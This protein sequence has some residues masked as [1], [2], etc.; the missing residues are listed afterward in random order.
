MSSELENRLARCREILRSLER[1]VVA[2]S[3]GVDSTFLLALAVETLGSESVLAAVG[4]SPSLAD[5]E[6]QQAA[7]LAESI[8]A[9][10][11]E[12][13]VH[14]VGDPE[15]AANPAN[16]CFHCKTHLF[17]ALTQLAEE[18]GFGYVLSGANADDAGDFRPGIQAG[19][20]LGVRSPLQEAGLTK[21]DI[22]AASQQMGLDTWD[23]PAMACLASRIPY[24]SEIT[25]ERL[26]RV[27]RAEY[28]LKDKGF[29]QCRVRDHDTLARVEVPAERFAALL[30]IRQ[31]IVGEIKSLGYIY[32]TLDMQG[33]R[34]GSMNE[35][36][37]AA[38]KEGAQE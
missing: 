4:V 33:F 36:L 35:S 34:S 31:E 18:R 38:Q 5:R 30:D 14:E 17:T 2:F 15:Y 8:G 27:E 23:K 22:R 20:R 10:M 13:E 1:V 37:T 25:P 19:E 26:G 11:V 9:D 7:E 6:R 16:R 3:A 29:T 21:D 28:V 24:G 32:V 12:V